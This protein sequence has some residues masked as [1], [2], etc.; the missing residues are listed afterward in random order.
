MRTPLVL[1]ALMALSLACTAT[2]AMA[3]G[4]DGAAGAETG[5]TA[6]YNRGKAVFATKLACKSCPMAGKK[7]DA[8]LARELIAAKPAALNAD[9][10]RALDVYLKRRFKL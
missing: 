5:D 4:N 9:E 1:R 8:A 2:F 3:S 6:A 7:L 10:G